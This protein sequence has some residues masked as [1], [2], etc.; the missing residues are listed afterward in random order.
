M[1]T[2]STHDGQAFYDPLANASILASA[3][4]VPLADQRNATV[5]AVTFGDLD[6]DGQDEAF[7]AGRAFFPGAC[8]LLAHFL[9]RAAPF[10]VD[11]LLPACVTMPPLTTDAP[12]CLS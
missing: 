7:I 6:G 1:F 11:A 2:L 10:Y 8:S 3:L 4:L 5:N 12:S 9:P